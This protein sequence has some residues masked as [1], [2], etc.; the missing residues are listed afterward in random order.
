MGGFG[1]VCHLFHS[2]LGLCSLCKA[3]IPSLLVP[4]SSPLARRYA[5]GTENSSSG[6]RGRFSANGSSLTA[7]HPTTSRR[8]KQNNETGNLGHGGP[9]LHDSSP[10]ENFTRKEN[11]DNSEEITSSGGKERGGYLLLLIRPLHLKINLAPPR[12]TANSSLAFLQ[13]EAKIAAAVAGTRPG[14]M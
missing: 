4:T 10:G 2:S 11:G 6:V 14:T 13:L 5:I 9:G 12:T 8:K 3:S 1:D 7:S